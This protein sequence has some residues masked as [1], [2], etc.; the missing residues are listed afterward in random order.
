[1]EVTSCTL[2]LGC[3]CMMQDLQRCPGVDVDDH[4]HLWATLGVLEGVE[5]GYQ[6]CLDGGAVVGCRLRQL[7]EPPYGRSAC[8]VARRI[9]RTMG[10]VDSAAWLSDLLHGHEGALLH[11]LGEAEGL[12]G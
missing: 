2:S 12:A 5:D 1:M 11:L 7:Y 4:C 10:K 8:R 3:R 9:H 6:L